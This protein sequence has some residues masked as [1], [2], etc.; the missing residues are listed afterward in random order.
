[1]KL[2]KSKNK[3]TPAPT[4][5]K[6]KKNKLKKD[7]PKKE[8]KKIQITFFKNLKLAPKILGGFIII[9]LLSS[10]MGAY[11]AL[12]L[13]DV[14]QSSKTMYQNILLPTRNIAG[15]QELFLSCT[16][17]LRQM[18]LPNDGWDMT[19]VHASTI[20]TKMSQISSTA[21]T[22]VALTPEEKKEDAN[23]LLAAIET[24]QTHMNEA[25]SAIEAGNTQKIVDDLLSFSDLRGAELDLERAINALKFAITSDAAAINQQNLTTAESVMQITLIAAGAVL[26]LSI[27]IG[28]FTAGGISKPVNRLTKGLTLLA[29]GETEV[30]SLGINSKD[31]IGQMRNAFRSIIASIKMLI[32]DTHILIDAAKEGQL[33][34]RADAE[35]H[36]G[37]YRKIIEGFNATLDAMIAPINESAEVLGALSEGNL[38]AS[39]QGNFEGDFAIIKNAL[40]STIQTLKGYIGEVSSILG[41]ISQGILTA[42]IDSEFKGDFAALK[43]AINTSIDAF[44]GVLKDINTAAE[45]VAQ[46]AVQLSGGSQ[47]IS[48]GAAEQ[49]SALEQLTATITE[50]AD[51]T[52]NNAQ[53]ANE[54]SE[55]SQKAKIDAAGGNEKMHMLQKAIEDINVSSAS[56]SKIIKA[57]DDIAFQTNILALNAAVEA[58]RAG[59]HGKGFAVVAEEVRNLAARSAKAAQETAE[60]IEGSIEKTAAGTKIA[61]ET[62]ASL[63]AIVEGVDKTVTLSGLIATASNEQATGIAQVNKGI[64]QLSQVVQSSSATAQEAAA[65]SEELAAQ[66]DQLKQMVS[67]FQLKDESLSKEPKPIVIPEVDAK[68][69]SQPASDT[70]VLNDDDFG[71]F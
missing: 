50:I 38:D 52:K 68:P 33:S 26:L 32:E 25:L 22:V 60:L 3:P 21:N 59:A 5:D 63:S 1:M 4:E 46:G 35:K 53:S 40:N 2:F 47:V 16:S 28:I 27:L 19:N 18:L 36:D 65:S 48:Q 67:R 64:E 45:E 61:D 62:A 29:A 12:S 30:P 55:L 14:S 49:A 23:L 71:K 11:A 15:V 9:A 44:N 8:K 41:N 43:D 37:A 34:V 56:I 17:T 51:Q 57:I 58:A 69:I 10:S 7:K 20:R 13:R 31:E 24:Y 6:P 42:S 54:A 70:I 66:A 39:V